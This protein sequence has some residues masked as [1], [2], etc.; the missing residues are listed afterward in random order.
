MGTTSQRF[1]WYLAVLQRFFTLC[2]TIY[3]I[4]LRNLLQSQDSHP[5]PSSL[6]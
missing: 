5:K 4:Y 2:W 1:G 6:C 3:V